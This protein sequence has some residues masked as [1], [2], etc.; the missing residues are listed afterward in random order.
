[1]G[2]CLVGTFAEKSE[3]LGKGGKRE[4]AKTVIDSMNVK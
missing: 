4:K 1:M 2:R 3:E